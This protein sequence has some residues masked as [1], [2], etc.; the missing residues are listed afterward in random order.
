MGNVWVTVVDMTLDTLRTMAMFWL[1][2]MAVALAKDS[3]VPLPG[4][5]QIVMAA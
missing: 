5:E 3:G 4:L 1:I 2:K